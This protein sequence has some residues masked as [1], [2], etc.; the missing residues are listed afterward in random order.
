MAI[1]LEFPA[2]GGARTVE[3]VLAVLAIGLAI[4][5]SISLKRQVAT[6]E[7]LATKLGAVEQQLTERVGRNVDE[8]RK[9]IVEIREALPTKRLGRFPSFLPE[10]V[11]LIQNASRSVTIF[12]DFPAYGSFSDPDTFR[13]YQRAIEDKIVERRDVTIACL[14][15]DARADISVDDTI[16]FVA[17]WR[18]TRISPA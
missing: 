9:S 18:F 15:K 14:S 3:E 5:H 6:V 13:V 4:L 17:K 10:I 7:A 12:C 16:R 2:W 1:L 11:G 8:M